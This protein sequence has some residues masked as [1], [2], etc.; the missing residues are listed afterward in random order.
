MPRKPR[1]LVVVPELPHHVIVRGNNRRRLFSYPSCHRTFLGLLAAATA[2]FGVAVHALV[3]MTNHVHLVAT[4]RDAAQLASW[5]KEFAQRYA[6]RRNRA[7][8]T[9]GKLFEQRYAAFPILTARQLAATM[10][11][12]E[13]NPV[14]A[15][16][17]D[18]AIA[19]PWSTHALNAGAEDAIDEV[20]AIWTPH[21]WWES[22]GADGTARCAA[23]RE[24]T[25]LRHEAYLAAE[26]PAPRPYVLGVERPDRSRAHDALVAEAYRRL[27]DGH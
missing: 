14:R 17:V 22:L 2:R 4:V 9:T 10:C 24:L 20:K 23:Y 6:A 11:Y 21:P 7:R 15:G 8:E 5:V 12:V 16:L 27:R 25:R 3:L 1:S 18:D 13:L 19:W 26:R